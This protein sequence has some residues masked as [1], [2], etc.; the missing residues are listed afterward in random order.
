[1]CFVLADRLGLHPKHALGLYVSLLEGFGQYRPDGRLTAVPDAQVE[2]WAGW[3]GPPGAFA[4]ALRARCQDDDG[5]L[6]GWRKRQ[7]KLLER[8]E[9]ERARPGQGTRKKSAAIPNNFNRESTSGPTVS[10]AGP[11]PAGAAAPSSHRGVNDVTEGPQTAPQKA[12]VGLREALE[13]PPE[14]DYE[15]ISS[16][17]AELEAIVGP[18]EPVV[19]GN[20]ARE[21]GPPEGPRGPSAGQVRAF[22]EETVTDT[23]SPPNGGERGA[24]ERAKLARATRT[25]EAVTLRVG[26]FLGELAADAERK[27]K[28]AEV[29]V[30]FAEAVFLYWTKTYR[31]PRALLDPKRLRAL[32]T[33]LRENGNDVGELFYALDGARLD[34]YV[35][36]RGRYDGDPHDRVEWILRDRGSVEAFAGKV[37]GYRHGTPHPKAAALAQAI[38]EEAAAGVAQGAA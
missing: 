17:K 27:T 38:A 3:D 34:D 12:H 26:Q 13:G 21:D 15:V 36:G 33:R 25:V 18:I 2:A 37:Q 32:E 31:K 9:R 22:W 29:R 20:E 14:A 6:R 30:A 1:V 11:P 23:I 16:A 7:G 24:G 8:Q 19:D 5:E 28:A 35:M 4:A 10:Y